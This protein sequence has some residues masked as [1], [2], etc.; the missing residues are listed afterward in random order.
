[1][2][3]IYLVLAMV[4]LVISLLVTSCGS[5]TETTT[6]TASTQTTTT[7]KTTSTSS[8]ST[9]TVTTQTSQ[10]TTTTAASGPKSGGKLII[11]TGVL[12]NGIIG[13]P[14]DINNG[15]SIR[16]AGHVMEGLFKMNRDS[17]FTPILAESWEIAEDRQSIM[18]YLRQ[19]IK[20]M[21]DTDFNAEAVK[22]NFDIMIE[23]NKVPTWKSVEVIDEH[24]VKVNFTTYSNVNLQAFADASG[25]IISPTAC[26]E[27]GKD[28]M[29]LNI[30]S[31]AA[32]YISDFNRDVSVTMSRNPNY[33]QKDKPYLDEVEYQFIPDNMTAWA[34]VQTGTVDV[35]WTTPQYVS[36]GITI[37]FDYVGQPGTTMSLIPDSKNA[38]SPWSN[39]KVR[40]AAEYALDRAAMANAFGYGLCDAPYQIA[41]P[42]SQ[43][44]IPNL[45]GRTYNPDKA[46]QLLTEAGYP[47]GFD[48]SIIC[49]V[50]SNT[51]KDEVQ[52]IQAYL[53]AVGINAEVLYYETAKY[54][55]YRNGTWENGLVYEPIAAYANYNNSLNYYFGADATTFL[56]LYKSEAF[57]TALDASMASLYPEADLL[58]ATTK[59]MF[60]E[61][62]IIPTSSRVTF[63]MVNPESKIR[64]L[65]LLTRHFDLYFN[66]EDCWLDR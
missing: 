29:Y 22:W 19:G 8:Q 37:G 65:G 66:T 32:F 21:D 47:D 17:S 40:Q 51:N 20:F 48:T 55:E 56:S 3:K 28:W 54:Y 18:F 59:V 4:I 5:S 41:T 43:A 64:D 46:K 36:E 33:W 30:V 57:L 23:N 60:D 13:Y 38:D 53:G 6:T 42:S 7:T 49:Q 27:H 24:T 16:I 45:E 2:K 34:L 52:A 50:S 25:F 31:T 58:Q 44:Y 15:A 35:W 26:K 62:M 61:A 63:W 14:A 1:M 11:V 39:E 9:T 10:P 12:P